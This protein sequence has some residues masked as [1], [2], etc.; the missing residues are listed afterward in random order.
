MVI[1]LGS[2]DHKNMD[3]LPMLEA[4]VKFGYKIALDE[5]DPN[6][7]NDK[8]L[9]LAQIIKIDI[10]RTPLYNLKYMATDLIRKGKILIGMK[11]EKKEEFI[12]CDQIGFTLFQGYYF[13]IPKT[14]K[15]RQTINTT[16]NQYLK[17]FYE[18]QESEPN[19]EKLNL[20]VSSDP[21]L[22][23]KIMNLSKK[24]SKGENVSSIKKA[25]VR[26]VFALGIAKDMK[27]GYLEEEAKLMGLFFYLEYILGENFKESLE[28]LPISQRI[29][30]TLIYRRGELEIIYS[31]IIEYE[32]ARWDSLLTIAM[33]LGLEGRISKIYIDS[34]SQANEILSEINM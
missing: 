3:I 2:D 15:N 7:V 17:I 24:Y 14:L 20:F 31:L 28:E 25:L 21:I 29:K 11:I 9:E 4:L 32:N 27:R 26:A 22:T 18:L 6:N 23:Y 8:I 33:A 13:E 19:Y 1:E 16:I 12:L 10:R 5:F 34:F 30:D